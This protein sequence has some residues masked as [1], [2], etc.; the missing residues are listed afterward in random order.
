MTN[1]AVITLDFE[2]SL[3]DSF[4]MERLTESSFP[5]NQF[6]R[7]NY[8][9]FIL[10]KKGSGRIQI[11]GE[12]YTIGANSLVLLGKNQ[13]YSVNKAKGLTG[14]SLCFS[15]CFWERTPVSENNCK[16]TLFNNID[17]NQHIQPLHQDAAYLLGLFHD[18]QEEYE[19]APY[20]NKVDVLAAFLKIL[21]IKVANVNS[22]LD[23]VTGQQDDKIY[24]E[25]IDLLEH[26]FEIS[27]DV[28]SFAEKLNIST[29]KLTDL[30]RKYA[31]KGAKDMIQDH[32]ITEAKRSLQ[33]TSGSIKEIAFRLNFSPYQ[34]SHFFKRN[35]SVSPETYRK[36][37]AQIDI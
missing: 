6:Y 13:V 32:L 35:T 10:V 25:F 3:S 7:A 9:Q 8:N 12:V 24:Y 34:F 2:A 19:T 27:H 16:A 22:L 28:A 17:A 14:Y 20:I 11:D 5:L 4:S 30:C 26:E 23:K 18:I 37:T 33:F 31:G 29:R 36:Q 21:M 15:D 1:P